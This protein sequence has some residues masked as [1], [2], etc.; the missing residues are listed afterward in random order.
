MKI[1]FTKYIVL[2]AIIVLPFSACD[3]YLDINVDPNRVT[4]VTLNALLP[5]AIESTSDAHYTA[6]NTTCRITQQIGSYF[7]YP[8]ILEMNSLWSGIYLG[9]LSN[10]DK[11][12][13]KATAQN[14]PHYSGIG[15]VLQALNLGLLT[16]NWEA[17][18]YSEAILGSDNF[19]PVYDSQET[20]YNT[21]NSLLDSAISDLSASSSVFKPSSDDLAYKGNISRWLKLAYTL[22][23][24]YAIHLSNKNAAQAASN[25]LSALANG[26]TGNADDFQLNYNSVNKNPFHTRVAL[27]NKTGNLTITQGS[28]LVDIMKNAAAEGDPRL[29]AMTDADGLPFSEIRGINSFDPN[30][31]SSNTDFSETTWHSTES[32]PILMVTYAEAK[33][34]E[35]EAAMISNDKNRAYDA[36]IAGIMASMEKLGVDGTTYLADPKVAVGADNISL[37]HIMKEKYVALYLNTESWVDMRRY[38]YNPSIYTGFVIPMFETTIGDYQRVRYP[39]DEFNRNGEQATANSKNQNTPMWRDQ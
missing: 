4:D 38:N 25:A 10:L 36:Y 17:V 35:A 39:S 34:I 8:D 16:D 1:Q 6:A 22:K 11:I 32:A 3:D 9:S 2:I 27:A 5:T 26:F 29:G 12:V 28:Y 31:P 37:S 20:N 18:P 13:S 15:K 19:K 23:A 33:F 21:I 7:G 14:A 30:A 24:R